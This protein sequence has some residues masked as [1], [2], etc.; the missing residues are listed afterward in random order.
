MYCPNCGTESTFGL[1]YCKH[2]GGNLSDTAQPVP[3]PP[4]RNTL[5]A[6]ILAAATVGIVL[7]GLGI[8]FTQALALVGPQP[9]GWAPPVHDAVAVAGIMVLLG[10]TTIALV[11]MML[12]KLFARV[13]GFTSAADKPTRRAQTFVPAHNVGQLPAPPIP[14]RSVT[15][16]TTRNFEPSVYRRDTSE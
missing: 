12:I 10:T 3:A 15:E 16:H 11:T 7:G 14:M 2:C 9:P 4:A 8:V 5:A 6:F 13:M 1:N